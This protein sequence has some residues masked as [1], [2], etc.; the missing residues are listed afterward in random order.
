MNLDPIYENAI[1]SKK[2]LRSL[3][4]AAIDAGCFELAAELRDSERELFPDTEDEKYARTVSLALRMVGINTD[5]RTSWIIGKTI[6]SL[7]RKKG[8]FDLKTASEIQADAERIFD[9]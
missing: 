3:K 2:A 9:N 7:S 1:K 4:Q 5:H 8:K 6:F